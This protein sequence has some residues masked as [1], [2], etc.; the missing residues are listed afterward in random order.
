[1]ATYKGI[2]YDNTNGRTRT[3]TSTD[4]VSFDGGVAVTGD[5]TVAGSL[6][7]RDQEQVL[8]KDNF[9]DLN[10]GYG[11][12][13]YEQTG[14]TFNFQ[15]TASGASAINTGTNNVVFTAGTSSA[16][17]KF[18]IAD[19]VIGAAAFT[20]NDLIQVADTTTGTNDGIYV[21]HTCT[22]A[23][24]VTTVEIKSSSLTSPDTVNAKF[25]LRQFTTETEST[26]GSSAEFPA[27]VITGLNILAVRSSSAGALQQA[28]GTSDVDFEDADYTAVG[29]DT[30]L[31]Q[32]YDAG[33]SITTDASGPIT[34]TLSADAQGLS[35]QGS[36]AGNGDVS[37]GG[38]TT[39]SSFNV[40]SAGVVALNGAG[41]VN[42]TSSAGTAALA[43]ASGSAVTV[44]DGV[45]TL[46]ATS[47]SLTE[48]GLVNLDLTGSGTVTI[49]GGG[50][51]KY[52]DETATLDFDGAG[53][54]TETGMTSFAITP[55]GALTM[56]GGGASKY[57]DDIATWD[58]DG[59]GALSETG[60][61]SATITPSAAI[62]L[63]A[64][65]ASTFSTSSGQ[66]TLTSAAELELNGTSLDANISGALAIDST[67]TSD[68]KMT[69]NDNDNPKTLTIEAANAGTN[70]AI[71]Q[72]KAKNVVKTV[73]GT[74]DK[75]TVNA[76]GVQLGGANARVTTILDED[77]MVSDSA[78]AL[79]T[80][81]SIKAYVDTQLTAEDLDFQGDSGTGAVDLDSQT[82]DIA[83]GTNVNTAASGQTLTVNLDATLTGLTE[84]NTTTIDVTNVRAS[85][86]AAS[87]V[88]TDSTGAVALTQS[89]TVNN[90]ASLIIDANAG[91]TLTQKSAL[92]ILS[93]VA[94][95]D[96]VYVS[97]TGFQKAQADSASTC[98]VVGIA[99]EAGAQANGQ[100]IYNGVGVMNI[101]SGTPSVGDRVY[102]STATAGAGQLTL[103]SAAGNIAYQVGFVANASAISGSLYQVIFQPQFIMEVG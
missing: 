36:S 26:A 86:G 28:T 75:I 62:T 52:G 1:M 99:A 35:V 55:S 4:T 31:Q 16:R 29:S 22:S 5:L 94:E 96:L 40:G 11:T 44:S 51:S 76:N 100:V 43:S 73:I 24:G 21:V 77:N 63:T 65:A 69:A 39:V 19:T 79:A 103:P 83:G 27:L 98:Y 87:I 81:Q 9:L 12:N 60:M 54:V 50:V 89:T 3:G 25:A 78:T 37:I 8:V 32:A 41:N 34:F 102:L 15:A 18:T 71:V 70:E 67:D 6:I 88:L 82:L 84:V 61:T 64:G 85:D 47:G 66:F 97:A 7:S 58:F 93:G 80:Q 53:A 91:A 13:A 57:G 46:S 92:S 45:L 56:Q 20:V 42:L 49:Q 17:A 68:I 95:F 14:L 101:P 38:T 48:T 23:G 30:P 59:S 74:D 2:G 33:A 10:F 72:L 90:N